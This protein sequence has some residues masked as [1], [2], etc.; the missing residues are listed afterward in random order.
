MK[1][2]TSIKQLVERFLLS[3]SE[4]PRPKINKATGVRGGWKNL[5]I[6]ETKVNGKVTKVDNKFVEYT[7][8]R[9]YF[10][11]PRHNH[12]PSK[13]S[14]TFNDTWCIDV[15]YEDGYFWVTYVYCH[16]DLMVGYG[17]YGNQFIQDFRSWEYGI[18]EHNTMLDIET[19]SYNDIEFEKVEANMYRH[20][21][22]RK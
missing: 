9:N 20:P 16:Y 17:K 22:L 5:A 18:F 21:Q 13:I 3:D 8:L 19:Q 4:H 6:T 2:Y 10:E 7:R 15:K 1:K 14:I 11:L 12:Y